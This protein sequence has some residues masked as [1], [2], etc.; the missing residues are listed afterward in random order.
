MLRLFTI[1]RFK[2][3]NNQGVLSEMFSFTKLNDIL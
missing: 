2:V 3:I 1:V